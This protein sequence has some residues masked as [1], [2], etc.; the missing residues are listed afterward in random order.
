[1]LRWF[2]VAI[3]ALPLV[4]MALESV[5]PGNAFT[6]ALD[7]WFSLHCHQDPS[8]TL[9]LAGHLMPVCARCTGLYVG[10][11]IGAIFPPIRG[12]SR[13]WF[14]LLALG[15]LAPLLDVLTQ[16]AGLRVPS[17]ETRLLTGLLAALPAARLATR[18]LPAPSPVS[19]TGQS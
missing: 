9:R 14:G 13:L 16:A 2:L 7:A 19:A 18:S 17:L 6:A 12:R 3:G 10:L 11:F 15:I 8:R 4:A 5:A 1:V